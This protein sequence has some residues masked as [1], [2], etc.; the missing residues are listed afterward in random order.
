MR[1]A[2]CCQTYDGTPSQAASTLKQRPIFN[3]VAEPLSPG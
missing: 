2:M 3:A 1:S